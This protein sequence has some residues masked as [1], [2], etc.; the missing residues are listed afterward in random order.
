MMKKLSKKQKLNNKGF[1]LVELV[2]AVAIMSIVAVSCFLVFMTTADVNYNAKKQYKTEVLAQ[3]IIETV[4]AKNLEEIC[5]EFEYP[6]YT[7][8]EETKLRFDVVDFTNTSDIGVLE[9]YIESEDHGITGALK[10]PA[11]NKYYLY[12]NNIPCGGAKYSAF[13]TING[14][15]YTEDDFGNSLSGKNYSNDITFSAADISSSLDAI[16]IKSNDFDDLAMEKADMYV[17]ES[18]PYQPDQMQRKISIDVTEDESGIKVTA[19][20]I[21]T[22]KGYQLLSKNEQMFSSDSKED[23]RNIFLF[24]VPGYNQ[25]ED[26]ISLNV[27]GGLT[28]KFYIIKQKNRT[29]SLLNYDELHYSVKIM[30]NEDGVENP[31]EDN[32]SVK[33]RTNL[34]YALD[35]C[36]ILTGNKQASYYFCGEST[37]NLDIASMITKT[38]TGYIYAITV[39]VFDEEIIS[40]EQYEALKETEHHLCTITGTFSE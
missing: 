15:L 2:I 19:Q 30:I 27:P 7:E 11:D 35:T 9:S 36:D 32:P 18:N 21:Y 8:N 37:N 4:K 14:D 13:I 39:D 28:T 17:N 6:V 34:G 16:S 12:A 10:K 3:N 5:M 1:T 29:D 20:H 40:K 26:E 24:Y 25:K 22:Y 23:L 33:I 38:R 31:R